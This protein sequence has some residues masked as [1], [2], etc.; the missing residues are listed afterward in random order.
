MSADKKVA[1]DVPRG[2]FCTKKKN[3]SYFDGLVC[4]IDVFYG[5]DGMGGGEAE[6]T[7]PPHPVHPVQDFTHP[8]KNEV[9][10]MATP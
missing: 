5:V 3:F 1:S 9:H 7:P 2:T 4:I 6:A 10:P 8:K